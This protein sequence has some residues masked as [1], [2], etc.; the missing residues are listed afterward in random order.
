M[1][2]GT[3]PTLTFTL[4]FEVKTIQK[5]WVTFSQNDKEVFTLN[6]EDCELN[7]N[8]VMLQLSQ[9]QTLSLLS[10]VRVEIQ[11]RVLTFNNASLASNIIKVSV[12]RILK[13]GVI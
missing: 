9:E 3:N 6:K 10:N 13:G 7:G 5:M 2:R 8:N 12:E 4:P 11:L 1:I